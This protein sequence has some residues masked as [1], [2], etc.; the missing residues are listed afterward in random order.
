MLLTASDDS[1]DTKALFVLLEKENVQAIPAG[2]S[3][4]STD[5]ASA[6]QI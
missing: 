2:A 4:T 3:T 6:G 1:N 5:A